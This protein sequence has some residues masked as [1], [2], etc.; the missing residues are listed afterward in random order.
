MK[1]GKP[2]GNF[3]HEVGPMHEGIVDVERPDDAEVAARMHNHYEGVKARQVNCDNRVAMM[4]QIWS[5]GL[6]ILG[7]EDLQGL[8]V[9]AAAAI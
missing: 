5:T 7:E 1:N 2:G 6:R 4:E 3:T 8:P 9:P